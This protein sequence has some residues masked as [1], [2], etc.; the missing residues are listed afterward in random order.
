MMTHRL[1]KL[2]AVFFC[3]SV[4]Q[5]AFSFEI[6]C[7]ADVKKACN[8]ATG[9]SIFTCVEQHQNEFSAPC[10]SK[11]TMA[12]DKI[13]TFKAACQSQ[14]DKFCKDQ[15]VDK[16]ALMGCIKQHKNEISSDC[17]TAFAQ[18]NTPAGGQP[19]KG[20]IKDQLKQKIKGLGK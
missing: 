13:N 16:G 3:L 9:A 19:S 2:V 18:A 15:K 4:H 20:N 6:E 14:I 5:T 17:K 7:M 10:K 12:K 8:E 11:M 1:M